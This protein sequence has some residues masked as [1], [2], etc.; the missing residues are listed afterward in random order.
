MTLPSAKALRRFR[1]MRDL[2]RA[3]SLF[4]ASE[5]AAVLYVDDVLDGSGN[6]L[7]L[8]KPSSVSALIEIE[9]DFVYD[10]AHIELNRRL[11]LNG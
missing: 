11:I 8:D 10:P 4:L 1:R 2:L 3:G 7:H 9:N 5:E 6:V